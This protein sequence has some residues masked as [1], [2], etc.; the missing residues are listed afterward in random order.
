LPRYNCYV[1]E[2]GDEGFSF[3]VIPGQGSSEW[4]ILTGVIVRQED[5][6]SVSGSIDRIKGRLW[7]H[8]PPQPGRRQALH[9]SSLR[10]EQKKAVASEL[11][12]EQF[13]QVSVAIC[14]ARLQT[15]TCIRNADALYMYATRFLLERVS[16]YVDDLGGTVE[17]TFS[18]RSRLALDQ[19][20]RYLRQVLD[21]GECQIRPVFDPDGIRVRMA[22]QVKM[23]QVADS[24]SSSLYN[25]LAPDFYGNTETAYIRA[26]ARRLYRY[27]G[28]KVLSYGLKVFPGTGKSFRE[29]VAEDPWI[30]E[31]EKWGKENAGPGT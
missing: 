28:K 17:I 10:H 30:G 19:L 29:I 9:W 25:A 21:S 16:W 14:K 3:S 22:D 2:S 4:F 23:L 15:G 1:D 8:T 11:R 20:R 13:T 24:C 7:G 18:N 26:L 5:D 12:D 31:L 27:R 6:L